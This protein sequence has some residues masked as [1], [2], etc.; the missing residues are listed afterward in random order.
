M[1]KTIFLLLYAVFVNANAT[2]DDFNL[3][4]DLQDVSQIATKSKLNISQTPSVVSVLHPKELKK[5]GIT[6]LYEALST[7]PGIELSMGTAGAKQINMRGNK[8]F[9]R[10]KIKLMID[11]VGINSEL[12]GG[13][14]FYLD[15]PIDLIERIEIIRGPA[16]ALYGS[17]AH[18]GVINVIT[19]SLHPSEHLVSYTRSSKNFQNLTFA[20]SAKQ[21]NMH[22]AL[23]GY[24]N[25]NKNSRTYKNYSLI[26]TQDKFTSYEN[27]TDKSLGLNITYDAL[28]FKS[29]WLEHNTQNYY[30]YGD[31]PISH[32]PKKIKT[33]SFF[34]ELAYA[35]KINNDLSFNL[36]AGLKLYQFGGVSRY[37]PYSIMPT[38]PFPQYDLLGGGIYKERTLYSEDTLLYKT[39]LNEFLLGIYVAKSDE[40]DTDYK[41]NNPTLSE[42][43]NIEVNNIAKDIQRKQ[44]ALYFNDIYPL[45]PRITLDAGARYDYYSDSDAGFSAKLALLY[46]Y[47]EVQNYKL[48]YHRSFRVPSFLELYGSASPYFGNKNL[49]SEIIDT[50][51]LV[52]HRQNS[53]ND[54]INVNLYY[55]NM[56]NFIGRDNSFHFYNA[57]DIS[58][59]GAEFEMKYSLAATMNLQANYSYTNMQYINNTKMPFISSHLANIMLLKHFTADLESGTR[60]RYVGAKQRESADT[61]EK[62][63]AKVFVDQTFTYSYKMLT[64]TASVKNI[65][66]ATAV[67]PSKLGDGVTTGTYL[68]DFQRDGRTFWFNV[69]WNLP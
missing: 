67:Y 17:L 36:K 64:L 19:K 60:I 48:L 56:S 54:W 47:D 50:V 63:K 20:Q 30:G 55:S 21:N 13:G 51:E 52:Y 65:F 1:I 26:T 8:S 4:Q 35:P 5:L 23:D 58:S 29:R 39:Q 16:S 66:N 46:A 28:S 45:M 6:T 49:D 34:S 7:V 41:V 25:N 37:I 2:F 31:W 22:I 38:P 18:V 43:I 59:Y 53:F 11:G 14:Y 15:M 57:E 42:N 40:T 3:T 69:E 61:R 10:D 27:Y 44:Y 68:E 62:I 9:I 32:D 33:K 12:V 24:F